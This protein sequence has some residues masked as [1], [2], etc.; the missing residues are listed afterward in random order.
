VVLSNPPYQIEDE[1][2]GASARP[3][4]HEI[5]MYAIDQLKPQYL[6]MITPSRWMVGGKGL[7]DYRVRMLADKHLRLIQDFPGTFDVFTDIG[8][9][10]GGVSYF[11]WDASYTG[12]CSFN[13][14]QRDIGEFDVAVRD[15]TSVQI[16]RKVLGKHIGKFCDGI[17]LPRK[18][19]GLATNF[20][21][22]VSENTPG[23][24]RCYVPKKHGLVKWVDSNV[25]SDSHGVLG[26]WKVFT[27]RAG[28]GGN[29]YKGG[30]QTVISQIF[31]GEKLSVCLETYLV[32]GS[33]NTKKEAENYAGYM[34]T[35]FYRLILSLRTITQDTTRECFSWV[36]DLG[37]YTNP[38]TDQDL[39][40]YFN[41][42]KKEIE[43]IESTIKE[44]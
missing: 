19:F 29:A 2:H 22:W 40:D 37:N 35:K 20:T 15:N 34:R 1:G 21:D 17:V 11:L 32:A 8:G 5:V 24:V 12:L 36:P 30:A 26:K 4:Y 41:L 13:D 44:I 28:W 31:V 9:I 23:A 6:C 14:V 10:A 39:Y 3:I 43:H 33:F 16:L 42:T 25:F 7:D 27:P 38:V 18:P